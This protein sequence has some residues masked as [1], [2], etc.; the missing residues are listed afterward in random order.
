MGPALAQ[1]AS[2]GAGRLLAWLA[3]TLLIVAL[4]VAGAW[5]VSRTRHPGPA[6]APPFTQIRSI[7][8]LPLKSLSADEQYF[9]DAMT[10]QLIAGLARMGALRV[11]A[12]TSTGHYKDTKKP[13]PAIARELQVD[14]IIEGSVIHAGDRVRI[15]ATLIR[16]ATGDIVWSQRFERDLRDVLTLQEEVARAVTS[17]VG[18]TLTPQ[19]QVRL[20]SARPVDPEMHRQVLL[21]RYHAA[22]STEEG[23]RKA[24]AYYDAVIGKDPGNALAHASLAEAYINLSGFY[25]RPR[26]AMPR[27]K[28]AAEAALELDDS[29]ADA[30]AALGYV[31]LLYDWDGPAA[32]REL[33]RALDLNSSLATARLNYAAYL[34]SQGRNDDAVRE[35]RQAVNLDPLSV[36]TY[37]FGTLYLLFAR[38]YDEAIELARKGLEFE[39]RSAF[40]MAFQGAAYAEQGRYA[41]AVARMAEAVELDNSLTLRA[42]RAHVLA[43]AGH[44][45]DARTVVRQV[46]NETRA[47]YFCPYEIGTV[48]VS[49][50]E[51]DT[52]TRWFRR[53]V[54]DRADCM[55][56][57]G[58]EPWID[59]FR[60]DPRYASLLKEIGLTPV[61]ATPR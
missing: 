49:L 16:G 55:P 47:R 46:E 15:T 58:V 42:L 33:L 3:G 4:A 34:T 30:H 52:A 43:V 2:P 36:G 21:G 17:K 59:P 56:W 40:T 45:D 10:E 61:S 41:E 39:P 28:R 7:A 53:G 6:T 26:E 19:A 9:A 1:P 24:I 5:L 14:A 32:E 25:I 8:V 12:R 35:I 48:Y 22:K 13:V 38:R 11:I 37:S 20:P 23:L 54:A 31:H 27:A 18:I 44:H 60:A 57:L 51:H 50:G 29:L